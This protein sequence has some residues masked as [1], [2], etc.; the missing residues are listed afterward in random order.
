[1]PPAR[2]TQSTHAF[3]PRKPT[4]E[5][6]PSTRGGVVCVLQVMPMTGFLAKLVDL[7]VFP[8]RENRPIPRS[9]QPK[10]ALR[11]VRQ[12][13]YHCESLAGGWTR[14]MSVRILHFADCHLGYLP[15]W[16]GARAEERADDFR[17]TFARIVDI[18]CDAANAV[19]LVIIAGDLFEHH[20]PEERTVAAARREF[21]RLAARHLPVIL[22]PG[23]HDGIS[24]T[25]SVYRRERFPGV[26]LVTNP[27][28]EQVGQFA[29]RDETV[30]V[31]SVAQ[32][33]SRGAEPL[34]KLRRTDE[35]GIHVAALH[36]TVWEN[37]AWKLRTDDFP[38][39]P[40]VIAES[41][42]HYV[43]LGHNHNYREFRDGGVLAVYPG[44]TEGRDF[45]ECGPRFAVIADVGE[46]GV[47]VEQ[48]ECHTRELS[49]VVVDLGA[50]PA[51]SD[52]EIAERLLEQRAE[53]AL[54][55]VRLTGPAEFVP[56]TDAIGDRLG[57][58]FF[59]VEVRDETRLIDGAL[60]DSLRKER[61][62]RGLFVRKM[63]DRAA[64]AA[65]ADRDPVELGLKYGLDE[66]LR[67][68]AV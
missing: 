41:G 48:R 14:G 36:A 61:T 64:S 20:V 15:A 31:Y 29:V 5:L 8:P 44:S 62:M 33:L 57:G 22:V 10:T 4:E 51:G 42:M 27:Q 28:V 12:G 11:R 7:V 25:G 37:P 65:D 46:H 16:L 66:F 59:Y 19:D 54:V 43:A 24:Y 39:R 38:I 68:G 18:A 3:W 6:P 50:A 58:T 23:N 55:R 13:A 34:E 67:H 30:H 32:D 26:T 1:M 60:V 63:L 17:R 53:T 21:E 2:T 49:E 45:G 47:Q 9:R 40:E 35:P 52:A 56:D